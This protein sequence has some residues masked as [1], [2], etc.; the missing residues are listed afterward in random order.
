MPAPSSE[1]LV[2]PPALEPALSVPA[3][4][5]E[6]TGAPSLPPPLLGKM[7]KRPPAG[8]TTNV[9]GGAGGFSGT[10][11]KVSLKGRRSSSNDETSSTFSVHPQS[12]QSVPAGKGCLPRASCQKISKSPSSPSASSPSPAAAAPSAGTG[13]TKRPPVGAIVGTPRCTA[14]VGSIVDATVGTEAPPVAAVAV[15]VPDAPVVSPETTAATMAS[16]A[17]VE[18]SAPAAPPVALGEASPPAAVES[19]PW[20]PPAAAADASLAVAG[21]ASEVL[22]G[23]TNAV[24]LPPAAAAEASPAVVAPSAPS[25]VAAVD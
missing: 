21:S 24:G 17:T 10:Q 6:I 14:V 3:P 8:R 25:A 22:A 20:A 1:T 13:R 9:D 18:P 5:F 2:E 23:D 12:L 11:W 19:P 16:P 4:P 15:L 7:T